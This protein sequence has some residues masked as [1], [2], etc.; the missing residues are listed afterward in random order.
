MIRFYRPVNDVPITAARLASR[1]F[2]CAIDWDQP[3]PCTCHHCVQGIS[4]TQTY[5]ALT[6]HL[7]W[8]GGPPQLDFLPRNALQL[9]NPADGATVPN[10]IAIALTRYLMWI[11]SHGTRDL[12]GFRL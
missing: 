1:D 8:D 6:I 3:R 12:A 2:L 5:P 10:A 9:G 11:A 4:T 7:P